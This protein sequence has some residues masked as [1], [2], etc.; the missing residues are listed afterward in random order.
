MILCQCA[1]VSDRT[2]ERMIGEGVSSVAEIVRRSGAGRRCAPC[3]E[4]I[5]AMLYAAVD[6]SDDLP[7]NRRARPAA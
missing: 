3:R 1:A 6:R 7:A 4:E 2:I 5:A